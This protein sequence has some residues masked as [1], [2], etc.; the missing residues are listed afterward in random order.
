[1]QGLAWQD[2]GPIEPR[3]RDRWDEPTPLPLRDRW[4]LNLTFLDQT[5]SQSVVVRIDDGNVEWT[6]LHGLS[7]G[8]GEYLLEERSNKEEERDRMWLGPHLHEAPAT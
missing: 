1:R 4:K 7:P 2:T 8:W 3:H 5:N 6:V